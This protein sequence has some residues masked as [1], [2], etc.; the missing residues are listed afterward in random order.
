M[1]I[2]EESR[3]RFEAI[4]VS[5]ICRELT[6]GGVKYLRVSRGDVAAGRIR[7]PRWKASSI[8]E[9][10]QAAECAAADIEGH[11][12][13]GLGGIARQL[14]EFRQWPGRQTMPHVRNGMSA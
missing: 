13:A 5:R 2:S 14:S 9:H 6:V 1:A 3:K 8:D 4:G 10:C 11:S 7:R 12:S